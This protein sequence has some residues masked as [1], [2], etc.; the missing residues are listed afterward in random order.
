MNDAI[1]CA[2]VKI[3]QIQYFL[4]VEKHAY[5]DKLKNCNK[6]HGRVNYVALEKFKINF[7]TYVFNS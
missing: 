2:L 1:A 7:I 4:F 6:C 5:G 3:T